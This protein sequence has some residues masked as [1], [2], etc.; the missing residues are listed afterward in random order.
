[1]SNTQEQETMTQEFYAL[2]RSN[3]LHEESFYLAHPEGLPRG[4]RPTFEECD[5]IWL[6]VLLE[7]QATMTPEEIEQQKKVQVGFVTEAFPTEQAIGML[8]F[9]YGFMWRSIR[10]YYELDQEEEDE[11][12]QSCGTTCLDH[13]SNKG[14]GSEEAC[15]ECKEIRCKHCPCEC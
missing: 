3:R 7:R 2:E 14:R 4:Q 8:P 15:P 10:K 11:C 12:C 5:A 1:M 9:V 6:R 13:S